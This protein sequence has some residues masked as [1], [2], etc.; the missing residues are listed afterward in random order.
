[1]EC[2]IL[3]LTNFCG[4]FEDK[5]TMQKWKEILKMR[6]MKTVPGEESGR[7]MSGG[8]SNLLVHAG[9]LTRI[10]NASILDKQGAAL[11]QEYRGFCLTII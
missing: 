2:Q 8:T 4:H 11:Q 7:V 1:M 6:S 5:V 3:H 10:Q 9:K